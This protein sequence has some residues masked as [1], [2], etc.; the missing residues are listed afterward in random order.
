MHQLASDAV[1]R[2]REPRVLVGWL[3]GAAAVGAFGGAIWLGVTQGNAALALF[4]ATGA[5]IA[6]GVVWIELRLQTAKELA[7][8]ATLGGLAAASRVLFHPL[9]D[10]LPMT[11]LVIACGAALGPGAGASVGALGALVSNF[12]LGQGLW[13]P[14]QM[15]GWGLCGAA[16]G[17]LRPLVRRRF[18]FALVGALLAFGF[19]AIQNLQYMLLLLQQP[20]AQVGNAFLLSYGGALSF[21]VTHAVTTGAVA[22]AAGPAL[23]RML[24][25]FARKLETEVIW[26]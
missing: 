18:G 20:N 11:A 4:L 9:P 10:V 3:I 24:D 1:P 16:G 8:V 15:L 2:R 5:L 26:T 6:L 19:G 25:R 22:L 23:I 17:L 14:W 21:D 13:T 12:A 7:L